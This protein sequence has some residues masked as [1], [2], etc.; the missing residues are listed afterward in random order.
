MMLLWILEAFDVVEP[1]LK[2]LEDQNYDTVN[3]MIYN[4]CTRD[5]NSLIKQFN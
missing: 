4:S 5:E 1:V 2:I 3:I